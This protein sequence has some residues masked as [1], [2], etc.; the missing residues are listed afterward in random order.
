MG[1]TTSF[2]P[3]RS[4]VIPGQRCSTSCSTPTNNGENGPEEPEYTSISHFGVSVPPVP[5]SAPLSRTGIAFPGSL[6]ILILEFRC[7]FIC[8][9]SAL[10][11]FRHALTLWFLGGHVSVGHPPHLH[12]HLRIVHPPS[13][14]IRRKHGR[15]VAPLIQVGKKG[16][17]ERVRLR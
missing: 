4:P 1:W 9:R 17:P 11:N 3:S 6:A 7:A 13:V 8:Q 5:P 14:A 10:V 2:L 16:P 12:L 15:L